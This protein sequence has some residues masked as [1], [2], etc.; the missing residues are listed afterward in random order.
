MYPEFPLLL[1]ELA[2]IYEQKEQ[3]QL[4]VDTWK[5]AHDLNPFHPEV[6]DALIQGYTKLKQLEEAKRHQRYAKILA[7]GGAL[8]TGE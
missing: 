5:R 8:S 7:A 2:K 6:Q 4:A 1:I 3:T